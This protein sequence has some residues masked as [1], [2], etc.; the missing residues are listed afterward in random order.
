MRDLVAEAT[1][2]CASKTPGHA[3]MRAPQLRLPQA[4]AIGDREIRVTCGNSLHGRLPLQ[5]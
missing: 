4:L 3:R 2:G 5:P 1:P